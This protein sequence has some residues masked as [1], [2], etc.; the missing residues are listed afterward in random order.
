MAGKIDKK[1]GSE[2]RRIDSDRVALRALKQSD[3]PALYK[4]LQNRLVSRHTFIPYPYKLSHA[5][6][7]ITKT[8]KGRKAGS[9]YDFGIELQSSRE[10]IG[11]V[12]LFKI[13]TQHESAE[14]GCWLAKPYWR[15]GLMTEAMNAILRF[16]FGELKLAR[17]SAHVFPPNLASQQ[18]VLG[19][20]FT[21]EGRL[22]KSDVHRGRRKDNLVFG[23]LKNEF[24]RSSR[25]SI[26]KHS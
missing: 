17:V 26:R 4:Y 7:F 5:E 6:E 25:R 16:A 1:R 21:P 13:S 22:R 14:V 19:C 15:Q 3:A 9:Q 11:V 2:V 12:G 23:I 24:R 18:M 10:V 20:G 8:Q